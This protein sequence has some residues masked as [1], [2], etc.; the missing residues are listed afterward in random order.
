MS[1]ALEWLVYQAFLSSVFIDDLRTAWRVH[2]CKVKG[3]IECAAW[4]A[5]HERRDA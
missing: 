3:C 2:H 1:R 4:R 5:E